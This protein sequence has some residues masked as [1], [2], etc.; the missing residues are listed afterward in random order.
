M[1]ATCWAQALAPHIALAFHT[2]GLVTFSSILQT[3]TH[4]FREV[5]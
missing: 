4:R 1:L 3:K 2:D 5:M